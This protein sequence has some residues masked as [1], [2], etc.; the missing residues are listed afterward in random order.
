MADILISRQD[1]SKAQN[2]SEMAG[3]KPNIGSGEITGTSM[4]ASTE[5]TIPGDVKDHKTVFVAVGGSAEA[6]LTIKKGDAVQGVNDVT[7]SVPATK[8]VMFWL[9]SGR[10]ADKSTGKI[11]VIADKAITLHG[12]EM[13]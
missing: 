11:T 12:Y 9:D 2:G 4:T 13:R 6:V 1:Y 7:I 10:F 3:W 8:T 5:Y